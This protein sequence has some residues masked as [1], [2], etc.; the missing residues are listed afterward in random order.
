[1]KPFVDGI[2]APFDPE[3]IW[4][5]SEVLSEREKVLVSILCGI[6]LGCILSLIIII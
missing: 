5:T 1:M 3:E 6:I 4:G 2:Q